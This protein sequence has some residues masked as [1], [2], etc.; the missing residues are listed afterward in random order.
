MQLTPLV[1][2]AQGVKPGLLLAVRRILAAAAYCAAWGLLHLLS[3]L[4]DASPS[5]AVLMRTLGIV[6]LSWALLSAWLLFAKA[7]RDEA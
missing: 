3:A 1:G 6:Y 7:A 2:L 4:P 5:T